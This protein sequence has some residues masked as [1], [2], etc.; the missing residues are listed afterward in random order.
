[1]VVGFGERKIRLASATSGEMGRRPC[2]P[3][4]KVPLE[5]ERLIV[6]V[7][8]LS[9][10]GGKKKKRAKVQYRLYINAEMEFA[11]HTRF[12]YESPFNVGGDYAVRIVV[13]VS[14]FFRACIVQI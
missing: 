4:I 13:L 1:M 9:A 3:E 8:S 2:E 14:P 10:I 11:D 5:D 12:V 6:W 7:E